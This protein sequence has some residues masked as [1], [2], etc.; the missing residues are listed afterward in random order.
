MVR[1]F[2]SAIC[3]GYLFAVI[4]FFSIV[5]IWLGD[6]ID[7][8]FYITDSIWN[9]YGHLN[10]VSRFFASQAN[11]YWFVNGRTVAH[12]LVQLFCGVLGKT[13]FAVANSFV[14][15]AFIYIILYM[16]G[17]RNVMKSPLQ[18]A[19]CMAIV[20]LTFVTKMMPTTQIGFV[21]MFTLNLL[22]LKLFFNHRHASKPTVVLLCVLSVLAG[23]GQE[24]FTLGIS[25][26]LGLWWL[27][28]RCKVGGVRTA[29][30]ICY[31]AGTLAICF[32]PGTLGRA[33]NMHIGF[34]ESVT[35]M[36]MS[37]RATYM[38]AVVLV[39]MLCRGGLSL[40]TVYRKNALYINAMAV[41]LAFNLVIGVYSNRQLFGIELLAVLVM[42]RTLP[43]HA[44][45]RVI[46]CVAALAVVGMLY[47]Q[48][49]GVFRV[50]HQYAQICALYSQSES[51][52]VYF[53]RTL[54]STN[55]L[56]REYRYYEEIVGQFNNDTHHSLQKHLRYQ[57]VKKKA[58]HVWPKFMDGAKAVP[59]T[60]IEYAPQHYFVI[61]IDA[62][63]HDYEMYW[64][65]KS[66]P[67]TVEKSTVTGKGWHSMLVVPSTPFESIDSV[68]AVPKK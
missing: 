25:A 47:A 56:L 29:M 18:V 61:S 46:T 45:N 67:L 11:H 32:S 28:R 58:L 27:H 14:Y 57:F 8:S 4:L 10:S 5:T 38:L 13:A 21:W 15:C 65:G 48:G 62:R 34:V 60:V 43:T 66:T 30:L 63:P 33:G 31:W 59:D 37:L 50:R 52:I 12:A 51:G 22:W 23:N 6:D 20:L 7:Y 1:K 55:R 41:L 36:L 16:C 64:H 17:V 26:A 53:D 49:D 19:C 42:L 35:Y 24:A 9:S 39:V 3:F 68:V 54:G 2:K 40:S 44:F